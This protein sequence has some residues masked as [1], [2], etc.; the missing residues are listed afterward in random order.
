MADTLDDRPALARRHA[1]TRAT[2]DSA[3]FGA[4][5]VLLA[6]TAFAGFASSFDLNARPAGEPALS[7]L[8]VLHAGLFF[9]W[10]AFHPAQVALVAMRAARWHRRLGVAGVVL[11]ASMAASAILVTVERTRRVVR[12]GTY[13]NNAFVESLGLSLGVL[14]IGLFAAFVAAAIHERRRPD[15]HKR[16]MLFA[17]VAIVGPAMVKFPAITSLHPMVVIMSPLIFVVPLP[18]Y[19]MLTRRRLLPA[20]VWGV[21]VS[22]AYHLVAMVMAGAGVADSLARWI[23]R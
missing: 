14:D 9:A 23:A 1:A 22:V 21:V 3:F 15:Q 6:I 2:Y 19:D 5:A 20:T 8:L 11:A 13:S 16:L 7:P 17:T 12:D 10:M 18:A 4:L